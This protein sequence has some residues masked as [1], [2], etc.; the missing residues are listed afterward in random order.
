MKESKERA[1]KGPRAQSIFRMQMLDGKRGE[2]EVE[3][4]KLGEK[5]LVWG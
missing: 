2:S 3:K 5:A 1:R 4:E